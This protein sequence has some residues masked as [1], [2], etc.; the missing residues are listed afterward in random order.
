M[1]N[2]NPARWYLT[3]SVISIAGCESQEDLATSLNG[4]PGWGTK[5]LLRRACQSEATN[6]PPT[7]IVMP[8]RIKRKN[9]PCEH[10]GKQMIYERVS[11]R[12]CSGACRQ[13]AY[14]GRKA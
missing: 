7:Y 13:A 1:T 11:A 10:C 12:F 6:S 9:K 5:P 3:P 2:G 4:L 8:Y 14:R